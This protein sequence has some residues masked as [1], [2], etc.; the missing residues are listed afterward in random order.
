MSAAHALLKKLKIYSLL[1]LALLLPVSYSDTTLSASIVPGKVHTFEAEVTEVRSHNGKLIATFHLP[2]FDQTLQSMFFR[3]TPYHYQTFAKA[4][5]HIIQGKVELY[6]G[7]LQMSQ[8][9]TIRRAGEITPKYKTVLKQQEMIELVATY[10]SEKAL[11]EQGLLS[12]EADILMMLHFPVSLEKLY[13]DTHYHTE[14]VEVLKRVEAF[15]HIQKL[16]G[17]R[18]NH[19]ARSAL[20]GDITPFV[21]KLPFWSLTGHG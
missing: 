10:L 20:T 18:T 14:I 2:L 16:S 7:T 15:N 11:I 4:S 13:R 19:P 8:P 1:D 9:K 6:R 5:K 12:R 21:K 17:K 3:V